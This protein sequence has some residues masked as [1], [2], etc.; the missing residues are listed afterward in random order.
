[1]EI[2]MLIGEVQAGEF[3]EVLDRGHV[4]GA[5]RFIGASEVSKIDSLPG[6]GNARAIGPISI[7]RY[8]V[9]ALRQIPNGAATVSGVPRARAPSQ[10]VLS[11]IER[12]PADMVYQHALFGTDYLPVHKDAALN[13]ISHLGALSIEEVAR[14][15]RV[16]FPLVQPIEVLAI[17]ECDEPAAERDFSGHAALPCKG[18]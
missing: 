1:M 4:I 17:N 13:A 7:A 9:Y 18:A 10:V 8:C 5:C 12:V 14:L 2:R 11:I 6:Y 3:A 15:D 16:P